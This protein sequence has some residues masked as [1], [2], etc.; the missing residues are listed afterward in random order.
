MPLTETVTRVE[1][2]YGDCETGTNA[3]GLS[4][5]EIGGLSELQEREE[6]CVVMV[7]GCHRWKSRTFS[8]F[9]QQNQTLQAD[10][11]YDLCG[12]PITSGKINA[13]DRLG[14]W[15]QNPARTFNFRSHTSPRCRNGDEISGLAINNLVE[16]E[17]AGVVYG[18]Q[19]R[20][21]TV[22]RNA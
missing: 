1:C 2:Q 18:T 8:K 13:I 9:K 4:C 7:H 10:I 20:S 14:R 6:K 21:V 19:L 5:S 15:L 3:E 11:G 17:K 22:Q 12:R 16:G